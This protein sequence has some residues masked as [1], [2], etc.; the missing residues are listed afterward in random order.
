[1]QS[2]RRMHGRCDGVAV[3]PRDRRLGGRGD[4][5]CRGAAGGRGSLRIRALP[6][7]HGHWEGHLNVTMIAVPPDYQEM[8]EED[9]DGLPDCASW[10]ALAAAF[11]QDGATVTGSVTSTFAAP[12]N[13]AWTVQ[14]GTVS[15]DGTLSLT[16]DELAFRVPDDAVEIRA[17]LMS[18]ESR[19]D[20]A[21]VMIGTAA[22]RSGITSDSSG[23]RSDWPVSFPLSGGWA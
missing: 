12:P 19:A 9:C 5:I 23:N 17:R 7:F 8:G 14:S 21:G 10:I 22:V 11:T 6:Q 13:Y 3:G 20:T 15:V 1:M 4:D 18:W 2:G 16:P